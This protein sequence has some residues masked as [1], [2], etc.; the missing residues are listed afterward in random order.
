MQSYFPRRKSRTTIKNRKMKVMKRR[1]RR[2][3]RKME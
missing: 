2:K 3:K 1:R